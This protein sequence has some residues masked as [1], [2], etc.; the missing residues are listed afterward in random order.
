MSFIDR[1]I[2]L[3]FCAYENILDKRKMKILVLIS[4]LVWGGFV[5]WMI[6]IEIWREDGVVECNMKFI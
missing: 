1:A 6:Q 2:A 4:W 5:F 3:S